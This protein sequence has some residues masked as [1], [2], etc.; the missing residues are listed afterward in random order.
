MGVSE[1]DGEAESYD[2]KVQGDNAATK[3]CSLDGKAYSH[4][5]SRA[6]SLNDEDLFWNLYASSV[7]VNASADGN[8]L[9]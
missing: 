6:S 3:D 7:V 2:A 5:P 8:R 9:E 1:V 4:D